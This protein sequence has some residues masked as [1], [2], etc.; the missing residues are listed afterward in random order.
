M[1]A[2]YIHYGSLAAGHNATYPIAKCM[3]FVHVVHMVRAGR[4]GGPPR[5]S[6]DSFFVH[7]VAVVRAGWEEPTRASRLWRWTEP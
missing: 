7:V 1:R 6:Q 4:G 3:F 5:E 2:F